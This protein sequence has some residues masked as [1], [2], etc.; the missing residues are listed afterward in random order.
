MA[1][2]EVVAAL[3]LD[4]GDEERLAASFYRA[5]AATYRATLLELSER[6]GHDR[7]KV[8]L[9]LE[10]RAALSREAH[11]HAR[12]V[13]Q[14][15]NGFLVKQ[16]VKLEPLNLSDRQLARYLGE[17]M[18]ARSRARAE[19]IARIETSTAR[20]DAQVSFFRENG[21]EPAFEF[22]GPPA[23][24]P[25]C[26]ALK[27]GG[28]WPLE[29]VL[30]VGYPHLNCT[31]N[32]H[33]RMPA[34][35]TLERGGLRPKQIS[36]GRGGVAGIVGE[37][38]LIQRTGGQEQATAW[39]EAL[40]ARDYYGD[41]PGER[42]RIGR[43]KKAAN[44]WVSGDSGER[45]AAVAA[46]GIV[47]EAIA[48]SEPLGETTLYRGFKINVFK[49][50]D[51]LRRYTTPGEVI[52]AGDTPL[53]TTG[54][55]EY[56]EMRASP[57]ANKHGIVLELEVPAG[58][59]AL[60]VAA[61]LPEGGFAQQEAEMVLPRG[62]RIEIIET[63]RTPDPMATKVKARLLPGPEEEAKP[64]AT[65][66]DFDFE[67]QDPASRSPAGMYEEVST[68]QWDDQSAHDWAVR[69]DFL[70]RQEMLGEAYA[71]TDSP[72][73]EET[74]HLA[75]AIKADAQIPV[76]RAVDPSLKDSGILPGAFV[77]ESPAYAR[78]HGEGPLG[79]N[80]ELVETKVRPSEL[81]WQGSA[82]EFLYAPPA[83]SP[84]W[85]SPVPG[86]KSAPEPTTKT[87][88][89]FRKHPEHRS[90]LGPIYVSDEGYEMVHDRG[91][92]GW[93]VR[94]HTGFIIDH[95]KTK[96]E[97]EEA[98]GEWVK[99]FGGRESAP[100][101]QPPSFRTGGDQVGRSGTATSTLTTRP[102]TR[103]W[104]GSTTRYSATRS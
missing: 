10:I 68:G 74:T 12:R 63:E 3:A 92:K 60:D 76:Y 88:M 81:A 58:T 13:T 65:L 77:S 67:T 95:F 35:S 30:S 69:D 94:D 72:G 22:R 9:S 98:A 15:M 71:R 36:A 83:D 61:A 104:A 33:A 18:R 103:A 97:A 85:D 55:P 41:D 93:Y 25:T 53:A 38:P 78:L 87:A 29:K 14:T 101:P 19:M 96:G 44:A 54:R 82:H 34:Q 7:S 11:D 16:A 5:K 49:D 37:H 32:W 80:Y 21:L 23:K 66:R 27:A 57:Q 45:V 42:D 39:I 48:E 17:H 4:V 50:S 59:K 99:Q 20:L 100:E 86:V 75:P 8:A 91:R 31:H 28:P 6:A 84:V 40:S 64:A 52:E 79:G 102:P 2:R 89:K 46:G 1:T 62:G 24:C 90:E 43:F 73:F 26:K 47:D 56:A 70:L 51:L